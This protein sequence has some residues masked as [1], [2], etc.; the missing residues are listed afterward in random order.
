M[1]H[2]IQCHCGTVQGSVQNTQRVNHGICYCKDCQ[3]FAHFLG[4]A[5]AILDG[6]GGT[7]IVQTVPDNVSIEQGAE[8]LACVRL[9]ESGLLRWYASCCNTA[10]GNTSPNF[11]FPF[12]GLVHSCLA[13]SQLSL[14]ETFGP[15][16]MHSFVKAAKA[17]VR[18]NALAMI[19][20]ISRF[21][22]MV[23]RCRLNGGYLRTPFFSRSGEPVTAPRVL[24]SAERE[25]LMKAL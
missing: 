19:P 2:P 11:R 9:T 18:V 25:E 22:A 13:S 17:P 24:S 16:T 20:G 12:V 5:E 23:A 21:I 7:E 8:R 3:A 15:P 10:I 14:Q 6:K 4:K 1:R